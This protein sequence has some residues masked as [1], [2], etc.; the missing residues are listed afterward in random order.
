MN[1][2]ILVLFN[3]A[4]LISGE[5]CHSGEIFPCF[6]PLVINGLNLNEATGMDSMIQTVVELEKN[7]PTLCPLLQEA[8]RCV[9]ETRERCSLNDFSWK[10]EMSLLE[11]LQ[12]ICKDSPF[13]DESFWH[14]GCLKSHSNMF[15]VCEA[16]V[17]H[18]YRQLRP[19][20]EPK[21]ESSI[22][23]EGR[24]EACRILYEYKECI[25]TTA[26]VPCPSA[27]KWI[28]NIYMRLMGKTMQNYYKCHGTGKFTDH[29]AVINIIKMIIKSPT[30][31][32][33]H[34]PSRAFTKRRY[35]V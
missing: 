33:S 11:L 12:D 7:V 27:T 32:K 14:A 24:R 3:T 2:M 6:D 21:N 25:T 9:K 29:D 35:R 8:R 15:Q 17:F 28:E 5:K 4:L 20:L 16:N 1:L 10:Q 34:L 23:L 31:S 26:A 30:D 13:Q 19:E 22:P 18:E